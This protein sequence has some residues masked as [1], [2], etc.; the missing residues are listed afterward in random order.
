MPDRP[1]SPHTVLIVIASL[2][3]LLAAAWIF[4]LLWYEKPKGDFFWLA[5]NSGMP[6]WRFEAVPLSQEESDKLNVDRAVN[7]I[8]TSSG[9]LQV[10]AFSTKNYTATTGAKGIFHHNPDVCWS[11]AGWKLMAIQPESIA[12]KIAGKDILFERRCFSFQ[13]QMQLVYFGALVGGNAVPY[14]MNYF[15]AVGDTGSMTDADMQLARVGDRRFWSTILNSFRSRKSLQGPSHFIRV[16]TSVK[17][18]DLGRG[19]QV[20]NDFLKD[21][22]RRAS[23]KDEFEQWQKTRITAGS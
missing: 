20:L 9:Q 2:I 22:L 12:V 23:F 4:P 6:G 8:V 19:D 10:R 3:A 16:S 14:R 21:W 1:T 13:G 5:E 18:D 7:Q 11:G 15:K 17:S